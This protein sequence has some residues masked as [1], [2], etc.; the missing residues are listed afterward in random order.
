MTITDGGK[1]VRWLNEIE[2]I[3]GEVWG[4]IW[5]TECIARVDPKDGA[6]IG[7]LLMDG[8]TK[9]AK[10]VATKRYRTKSNPPLR[11]IR[12]WC[13]GRL[14]PKHRSSLIICLSMYY[15]IFFSDRMCGYSMDVLN[16]IAFDAPTNRVWVTG[17]QWPQLYEIEV[18]ELPT[19]ADYANKL[20]DARHRCT[21]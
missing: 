18:A 14:W 21:K 12:L 17:K 1:N 2:Y 11:V 8:L 3:N 7:W 16:G 4:M 6:V 5:Q 10:K 9:K 20:A 19:H 13:L 15:R